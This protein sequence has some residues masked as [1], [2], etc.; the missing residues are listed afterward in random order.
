MNSV[1]EFISFFNWLCLLKKE[2][3]FEDIFLSLSPLLVMIFWQFAYFI[4]ILE[5]K[6]CYY[7]RVIFLITNIAKISWFEVSSFPKNKIKKESP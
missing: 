2:L 1:V 4:C 5:K 3:I 7:I 6:E